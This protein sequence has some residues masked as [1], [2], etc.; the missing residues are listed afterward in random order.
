MRVRDELNQ[1]VCNVS[2][3]VFDRTEARRHAQNTHRV[4]LDEAMERGLI[5]RLEG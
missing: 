2:G 4:S 1:Y 5:E 3:E